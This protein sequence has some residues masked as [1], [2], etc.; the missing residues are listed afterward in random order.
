MKTPSSIIRSAVSILVI[1]LTTTTRHQP[2][3]VQ[4][5]SGRPSGCPDAGQC[6]CN[7]ARGHAMQAPFG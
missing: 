2:K 1:G 5:Q 4:A 3:Q 6:T 7:A